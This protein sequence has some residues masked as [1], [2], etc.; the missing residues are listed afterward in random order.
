MNI[1]KLIG[2]LLALLLLLRLDA[3]HASFVE[4]LLLRPL[5]SGAVH[6]RVQFRTRGP[7]HVPKSIVQIVERYGVEQ[8]SLSLTQGRWRRE[9]WGVPLDDAPVSSCPMSSV[10]L[11][12]IYLSMCLC[13]S[14]V[15]PCSA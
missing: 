11:Y 14:H 4:E 12:S 2:V 10:L 7:E 8:L 9:R 3:A 15:R 6:A 1:V 5:A 13:F